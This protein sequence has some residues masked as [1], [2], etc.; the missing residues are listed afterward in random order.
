MFHNRAASRW[1]LVVA[2]ILVPTSTSIILGSGDLSQ[3]SQLRF[4]VQYVDNASSDFAARGWLA[5][6]SLFR[7]NV[8]A[9]LANWAEH[10]QSAATLI[11]YVQADRTLAR[12][13]GTF[14]NSH[15]LGT[16]DG[17]SVFEPGPLSKIRTGTNRGGPPD[18][19]L[20]FNA[21]FVDRH[22]W[23]DPTPFDPHDEHVPQGRADFVSIVMHEMGHALGIAGT[24]SFAPGAAYGT[25]PSHANPMDVLS[26]FGGSGTPLDA[27]QRPNPMFFRGETATGLFGGHVPL[28]HVGPGHRLHAQDFYHLGTCGDPDVL[29]RSLMNG[30]TMP[31]DGSR[32]RLTPL[33]LA[34][35]ADLGYPIRH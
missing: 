12:A 11:V 6:E 35:L 2:L 32:L 30:C 9:A 7:R 22:Y 34:V 23:L 27:R 16:Q 14:T 1:S 3:S 10:L 19:Y 25:L 18:V 15:F 29:A 33:D 4:D 8:D 21:D 20:R 31:I 26:G 17:V 5:P 24:R 13:G 28:S